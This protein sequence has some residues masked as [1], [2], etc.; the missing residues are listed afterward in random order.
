MLFF[1]TESILYISD[2]IK[3]AGKCI[4]FSLIIVFILFEIYYFRNINDKVGIGFNSDFIPLV[5]YLDTQYP[6]KDIYM[7]TDAL[8]QYIYLLLAKRMSPY[9]FMEDSRLIR[10]LGGEIDVTR[11]GRYHFLEFNLD[12]EMIYVIEPDNQF[13]N[14]KQ[15]MINI[16]KTLEENNFSY[17]KYNNFLIYTYTE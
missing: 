12:K 15:K 14:R 13:L 5:N 8:Q 6:D 1:A 11:V 16:M 10:Y 3:F 2:N 4:I 7:E 9:E 17:V